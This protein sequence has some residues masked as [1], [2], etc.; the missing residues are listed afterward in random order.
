MSITTRSRLAS[1]MVIAG[2]PGDIVPRNGSRLPGE[3]DEN[4]NY[5]TVVGN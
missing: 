4:R 1:N 3:D 2:P 5:T